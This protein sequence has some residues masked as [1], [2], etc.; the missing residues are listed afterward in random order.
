MPY[1]HNFY[2][3][4]ASA[5]LEPV[6]DSTLFAK[7]LGMHIEVINLII[8]TL[9]DSPDEIREMSKWIYDNL[10]AD[11]PVHFTRFHPY[12]KLQNLP[13]TPLETLEM[14]YDIAAKEG[15]RYIYL[16]NVPNTDKENTLCPKCQKL[17][18][19]RGIFA[20][21]EYNVTDDMTCPQCGEAIPIF[22]GESIQ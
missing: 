19:R 14:A 15:L 16:G 10:G 5:K 22:S 13:P 2:R 21:E 9:N 3:K 11:T 1:G 6:L 17:L 4:I 18:I 12:Y 7:E 20:V 8:P